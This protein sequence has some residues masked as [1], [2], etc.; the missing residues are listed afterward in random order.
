MTPI[1]TSRA[2]PLSVSF[3]PKELLNP[4]LSRRAPNHALEALLRPRPE[5]GYPPL[6]IGR[7]PSI[8]ASRLGDP[9]FDGQ[10]Q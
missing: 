6:R 1:A 4:N 2:S 7:S 3:I 10:M 8:A 5:T 9:S